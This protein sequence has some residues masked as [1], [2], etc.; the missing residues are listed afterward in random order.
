MLLIILAVF[1]L[2]KLMEELDAGEVMVIQHVNGS[3]VTYN[4]PGPKA[5][6]F[7]KVT[8][9][10][11]RDQFW[12]DPDK[13]H[14][15]STIGI[16]FNDGGHADM[17]GSIAWEMPTDE[18]S[19][20]EIHKRYRTHEALE[21]QLVQSVVEKAVYMTGPLMSSSESYA[22]RR[23]ELVGFIAD[24]VN[25]G[26]YRTEARDVQ[27]EDQITGERKTVKQVEIKH[28]TNVSDYL[29]EEKS[30]LE[31]FHLK[32]FNLAITEVKYDATVETQIKA[33]QAQQAAAQQS[34][35][36][37]KTAQQNAIT[38]ELQGKAEAAKK[39]WAAKAIAAEAIAQADASVRI[40]AL[41][42]MK[43]QTNKVIAAEAALQVAELGAKEADAFKR[44]EELK[45]QGEA[46]RRRAVLEADNAL[47]KKLETYVK[48]NET[49]A[50]AFSRY[51]GAVV[52]SV[53]MG[54][55]SG[56]STASGMGSMQDMMQLLTLKAARDLSLDVSVSSPKPLTPSVKVGSVT[57]TGPA[58]AQH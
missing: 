37:A 20:L 58:L 54:G 22:A 26:I 16:R 57:E 25:H 15:S 2:P 28:S 34:I 50:N 30:P 32:V 43:A 1:C 19:I 41:E 46:A 4:T 35:V 17:R 11:I 56:T 33:Q 18:A 52:P 45:G 53:V 10:K 7:G 24:Q 6:W 44:S 48:V 40:T 39:E 27:H 51:G 42:A 31:E 49:W 9:Y 8:K 13:E 29:R 36:D 47:E 23:Q 3:L 5:Q 14:G 55:G 12:F 38:A 21:R